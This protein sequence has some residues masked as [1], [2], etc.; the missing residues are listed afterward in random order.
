MSRTERIE[1]LERVSRNQGI[2][3]VILFA[4]TWALAAALFRKG[5]LSPKDLLADA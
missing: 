4:A 2:A 3:I 1:Y 5:I